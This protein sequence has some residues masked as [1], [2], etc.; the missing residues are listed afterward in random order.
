M[1]TARPLELK[2]SRVSITFKPKTSYRGRDFG[3]RDVESCLPKGFHQTSA[4]SRY[5]NYGKLG[6]T[7]CE[8]GN[9]H[10]DAP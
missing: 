9:K 10:V 3:G 2:H 7:M 4:P 1:V 8:T 6:S 5:I